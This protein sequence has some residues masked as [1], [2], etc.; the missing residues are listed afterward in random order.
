MCELIEGEEK[1]R[2]KLLSE[3]VS[4]ECLNVVKT[5]VFV[6]CRSCSW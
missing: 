5:H 1:E 2:W 6:V 3:W 4:E